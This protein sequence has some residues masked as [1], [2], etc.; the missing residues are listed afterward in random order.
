MWHEVFDGRTDRENGVENNAAIIGGGDGTGAVAVVATPHPH[1]S[2]LDQVYSAI[3]AAAAAA[4]AAATAAS[5][6]DDNEHGGDEVAVFCVAR[7]VTGDIHGESSQIFKIVTQKN[8]SSKRQWLIWVMLFCYARQSVASSLT[9]ALIG[10]LSSILFLKATNNTHINKHQQSL[11]QPTKF[12]LER[13][14]GVR[15]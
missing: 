13:R 7:K 9:T 10:A 6:S 3:A 11:N 2:F 8:E 14:H 12:Q 5:A 15:F 4:A 1:C